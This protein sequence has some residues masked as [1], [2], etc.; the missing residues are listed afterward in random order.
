MIA[1]LQLGL[2]VENI[3]K[4]ASRRA[5]HLCLLTMGE[6]FHPRTPKPYNLICSALTSKSQ[7]ISGPARAA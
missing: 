2:V 5:F 4:P 3:K 6:G 7:E 1:P